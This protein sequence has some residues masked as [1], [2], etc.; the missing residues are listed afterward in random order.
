MKLK[1]VDFESIKISFE[2][3]N[4]IIIINAEPFKTFE[5]IKSKALNKF[6]EIPSNIHFYYMGQD[7]S[8]YEKEKIGTIFNHKEQAKILLRLPQLK[9][10]SIT[11]GDEKC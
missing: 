3:Q 7:L 11:L 9:I 2:F 10:K 6:M 4:K 1:S 8:K 5:E